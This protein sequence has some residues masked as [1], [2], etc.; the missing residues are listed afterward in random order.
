LPVYGQRIISSTD[1][2]YIVYEIYAY[3]NTLKAAAASHAS[4]DEPTNP[5]TGMIW[6]DTAVAG[7]P[8]LKVYVV[9]KWFAVPLTLVN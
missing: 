3:L 5:Y 8:M 4:P 2:K 6:L 7:T 1:W 9:D